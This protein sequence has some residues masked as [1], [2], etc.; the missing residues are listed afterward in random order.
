MASLKII[1][2][3]AFGETI[4]LGRKNKNVRKET[5]GN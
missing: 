1:D 4:F 2:H 5:E 3:S